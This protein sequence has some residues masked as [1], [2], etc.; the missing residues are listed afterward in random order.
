[1]QETLERLKR[2]ETVRWAM[3]TAQEGSV[4]RGAGTKMAVFAG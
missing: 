3:I 2:G 1:M 4:P